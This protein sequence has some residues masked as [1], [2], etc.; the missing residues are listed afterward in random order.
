M[1]FRARLIGGLVAAVAITGGWGASA[2]ADDPQVAAITIEPAAGHVFGDQPA[3][4]YSLPRTVGI[5]SAGTTTLEIRA[6]RFT[7]PDAADFSLDVTAPCPHEIEATYTCS[8]P[9]FFAPKSE[10]PKAARLE[11]ES[12]SFEGTV[13]IPVSGNGTPEVIPPPPAPVVSFVGKPKSRITTRSPRLKKL[14]VKFTSDQAGSSFRCSVDGREFSVC[15]SPKV[16]RGLKPG[17][18]SIAVGAVK[19]G[20]AGPTRRTVFTVVRKR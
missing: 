13:S 5:R 19:D 20:L 3:G 8:F 18:H 14:T 16:L 4:E 6:I 12:N 7:G 15:R 17:K 11:V 1:A 9:I 10:G 2:S